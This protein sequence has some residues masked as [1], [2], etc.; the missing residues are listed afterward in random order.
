MRHRKHIVGLGIASAAL[1]VTGIAFAAW[2]AVGDG[3]GAAKAGTQAALTTSSATADATTGDLYPGGSGALKLEVTNPNS[4]QVKITDV[5][6]LVDATHFVTS[7]KGANC[8]DAS[9]STHPTGVTV[10]AHSLNLNVAPGG[11]Y[12]VSVPAV[13]ALSNVSDNGCQGAVFTIPVTITS[14]SNP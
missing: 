13:V 2:T 11:P 4:Y 12:A 14:Q 1:F 7:D 5:V 9:G 3:T 10:S 8:T 6:G